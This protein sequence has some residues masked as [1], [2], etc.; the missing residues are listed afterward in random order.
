V[1]SK[2]PPVLD[3]GNGVF[4]TRAPSAMSTP[5]I[6]AKDATAPEDGGDELLDTAIAAIGEHAPVSAARTLD[7]RS[8]VEHRIVAVAGASELGG[9]HV[10]VRAA[11][12][13]LR[14]ARPPVVLG[15]RRGRMVPRRGAR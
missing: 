15:L 11:D 1:V 14:I 3:P 9:H 4:D 5:G 6:V 8:S 2:D 10:E 12:E 7:H 13:D